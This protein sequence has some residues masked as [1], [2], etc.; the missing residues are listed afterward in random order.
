MRVTTEQLA[1]WAPFDPTIWSPDA[2]LPNIDHVPTGH[3]YALLGVVVRE[4]DAVPCAVY[5][6][7]VSEPVPVWSRPLVEVL[8]GP[9][10]EWAEFE[11]GT[12]STL[13]QTLALYEGRDE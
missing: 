8:E 10:W 4:K 1:L 12:M 3:R 5:Q 9:N 6:R 11:N 2:G 7:I 13:A